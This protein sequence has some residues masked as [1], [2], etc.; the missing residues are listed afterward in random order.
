VPVHVEADPHDLAGVVAALCGAGAAI[1]RHRA[2]LPP[3]SAP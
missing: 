2:G 3:G 1:R